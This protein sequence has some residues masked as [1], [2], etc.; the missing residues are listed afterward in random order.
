MIQI[1]TRALRAALPATPDPESMCPTYY[2]DSIRVESTY[3]GC[4]L[5]GAVAPCREGL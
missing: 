4:T 1:P 5:T 3:G 2:A